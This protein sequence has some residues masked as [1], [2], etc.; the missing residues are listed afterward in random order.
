MN[1]QEM[2]R[3][4]YNIEAA[5][6]PMERIIKRLWILLIILVILLFA[7]NA[8]WLLYLNQYE[9]ECYSETYQQDG[10]GLNIIGDRNGVM[11][12]GAER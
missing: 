1:E 7:S 6:A 11:F 12:D 2:N 9:V 8:A 4:R 10:N 5:M 3:P